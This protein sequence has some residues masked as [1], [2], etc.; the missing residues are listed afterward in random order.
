[1]VATRR[2]R[3]SEPLEEPYTPPKRAR[4]K[5]SKD[6]PKKTPASITRSTASAVLSS[7]LSVAETSVRP[8]IPVNGS[9]AAGR[10]LAQKVHSED[11]STGINSAIPNAQSRPSCELLDTAPLRSTASV[12]R[13][14]Q[15]AMASTQTSTVS[16]PPSRRDSIDVDYP[17]RVTPDLTLRVEALSENKRKHVDISTDPQDSKRPEPRERTREKARR[18]DPDDDG[19]GLFMFR[20]V[21]D[22]NE[23]DSDDDIDPLN[24][25]IGSRSVPTKR[26]SQIIKD[27]RAELQRRK[28]RRAGVTSTPVRRTVQEKSNAGHTPAAKKV[29]QQRQDSVQRDASPEGAEQSNLSVQR[30]E[31]E[32]AKSSPPDTDSPTRG[33]IFGSIG[34]AGG[35]MLSALGGVFSSPIKKE[36]SP[37]PAPQQAQSESRKRPRETMSQ[38]RDQ[39]RQRDRDRDQDQDQDQVQYPQLTQHNLAQVPS[40]DIPERDED[41]ETERARK[42]FVA[43][44]GP[45]DPIYD[46]LHTVPMPGYTRETLPYPPR[47]DRQMS[48]QTPTKPDAFTRRM[49]ARRAAEAAEKT[50]ARGA[51]KDVRAPVFGPNSHFLR[52]TVAPPRD[53]LFASSTPLTEDVQQVDATEATP[54]RSRGFQPYTE[55]EDEDDDEQD[56]FE[57]PVRKKQKTDPLPQTPKSALRAPG[58]TAKSGR[59]AR[60]NQNPIASVRKMSP[61]Y[62]SSKSGHYPYSPDNLFNTSDDIRN[63]QAQNGQSPAATESTASPGISPGTA[64]NTL[65]NSRPVHP[66]T[67]LAQY[68]N[69]LLGDFGPIQWQD[70][71]DPDWR[72]SVANPSPKKFGLPDGDM[73][74]LDDFVDEREFFVRE[75]IW[76]SDVSP[77]QP[78]APKP[79]H[80]ELP[81]TGATSAV[82]YNSDSE[83][84]IA[85]LEKARSGANKHKPK[86]PSRLAQSTSLVS[87]S[88]SPDSE[89]PGLDSAADTSDS[90]AVQTPSPTIHARPTWTWTNETN[91]YIC[92]N[93]SYPDFAYNQFDEL[94]PSFCLRNS[95]GDYDDT[96]VG[97]DDFTEAGRQDHYMNEVYNEQW[98]AENFKWDKPQTYE[99]SGASSTYVMGLIDRFEAA[100]PEIVAQG[101]RR[102]QEEWDSHDA[103]IRKAQA[104]G[105]VLVATYPDR[106]LVEIE[107]EEEL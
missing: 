13:F 43:T 82:N 106:D 8:P 15:V 100:N 11:L 61:I 37:T 84:E 78:P 64:A 83:T 21:K 52:K 31:L 98:A 103:A 38:P 69:E 10:I 42:L 36:T 70:D 46:H 28:S 104:E 33:G 19:P 48:D 76:G 80:A 16:A 34:R 107:D 101:D 1:M 95:Q 51:E 94:V 45:V 27:M 29:T 58:S 91:E 47:K 25:R 35:R 73:D 24:Y 68:V 59:S 9:T 40:D 71:S 81:K 85:N 97:P 56:D 63:H 86:A 49:K 3:A 14:Q 99:E 79:S 89:L 75:K 2:T 4:K 55:H 41:T 77:T 22:G 17:T 7:S 67:Q 57:T 5:K 26:S 72:P 60:F 32:A 105:N 66:G 65:A 20:T 53:A 96:I 54:T 92:S 39:R 18:V 88:P 93:P 90:S 44:H 62:G 102:T 23:D 30:T 50:A 12:A 87:R 6:I 74:V